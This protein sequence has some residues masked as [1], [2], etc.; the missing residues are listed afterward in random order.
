MTSDGKSSEIFISKYGVLDSVYTVLINCNFDFVYFLQF[1]R[2]MLLFM[3]SRKRLLMG[4]NYSKV[5]F[6]E[7]TET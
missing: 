6:I 3:K 4:Q 5:T 7:S 2:K 1:V